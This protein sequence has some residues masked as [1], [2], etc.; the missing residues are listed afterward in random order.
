[1]PMNFSS[2]EELMEA[3]TFNN[4]DELIEAMKNTLSEYKGRQVSPRE[5]ELLGGI[6]KLKSIVIDSKNAQQKAVLEALI[7]QTRNAKEPSAPPP[8][9]VLMESDS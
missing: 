5:A 9:A 4:F 2:Y 7:Q 8:G 3:T 6:E 1:M